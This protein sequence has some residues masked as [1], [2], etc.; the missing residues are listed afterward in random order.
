MNSI[1]MNS[2][3]SKNDVFW[4]VHDDSAKTDAFFLTVGCPIKFVGPVSANNYCVYMYICV[5]EYM[6]MPAALAEPGEAGA[7]ALYVGEH[8]RKY[9]YEHLSEH[10]LYEHSSRGRFFNF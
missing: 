6:Y 2:T 3:S 5:Y 8:L 10:L 1:Q 4:C 9:L 7:V